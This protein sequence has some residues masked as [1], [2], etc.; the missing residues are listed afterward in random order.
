ML[1]LV[2]T[3]ELLAMGVHCRIDVVAP[4]APIILQSCVDLL[5]ELE[6][7]WSRF[8]PASDISRLNV[9]Q[10]HPV[11]IDKRTTALIAAMQQAVTETAGT[12]NPTQLPDQVARET[13]IL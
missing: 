1:T 11:L 13:A 2:S 8:I 10:G 7:L 12:F 6:N 4:D 5:V 3:R 9:A